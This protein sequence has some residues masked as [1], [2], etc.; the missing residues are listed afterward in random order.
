MA[1]AIAVS[2]VVALLVNTSTVFAIAVGIP[3]C[4]PTLFS[5]RL[6]VKAALKNTL[7]VA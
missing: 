1:F 5:C 2:A 7:I 4:A 3:N 6:R